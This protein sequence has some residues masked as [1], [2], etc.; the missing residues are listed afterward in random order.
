MSNVMRN[1]KSVRA[2]S[3]RRVMEAVEALDYRAD[4]AASVLRSGRSNVIAAIVPNMQNPFFQ[5][6]LGAIEKHCSADGFGLLVSSSNNDE[7]SETA[8]IKS[9]LT[10]R[11]A[12]LFVIPCT[13][14]FPSRILVEASGVPHVLADRDIDGRN[15]DLIEIDNV[16]AGRLAARH[17]KML[18]HKRVCL[19]APS[20]K[21]GNIQQ[22]ID[23]ITTEIGEPLRLI[24][25]G[26]EGKRLPQQL[27]AANWDPEATAAIALTNSATLRALAALRHLGMRVPDDVSLIGFDD[28]EWMDIAEPSITAIK[29]PVMEMGES[30]WNALHRQLQG[31][32]AQTPHRMHVPE[33]MIRNST[34]RARGS[35]EQR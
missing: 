24:E 33:L 32:T 18:G 5:S 29:Q 14:R 4:Q 28:Y 7:A 22:R 13:G 25:V 6:L 8:R 26:H 20:L 1:S 10:W 17:L 23:G 3:R 11:P 35:N 15:C 30:A 27:L 16:E 2:D 12:G 21:V 19:F 34:G 9:L 31:H